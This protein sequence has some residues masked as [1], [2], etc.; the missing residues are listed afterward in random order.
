MCIE[1]KP[2]ISSAVTHC[3][4]RCFYFTH[5]LVLYMY[6][7]ER[8]LFFYMQYMAVCLNHCASHM[9]LPVRLGRRSNI[10]YSIRQTALK[11]LD[12]S[13]EAVIRIPNVFRHMTIFPDCP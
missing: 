1:C 10:T 4:C 7:I 13:I 3:V 11:F 12:L 9:H 2:S 8:V 5:L 6:L